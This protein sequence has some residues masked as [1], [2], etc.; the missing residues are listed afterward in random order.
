MATD[1]TIDRDTRSGE[2]V[3]SATSAHTAEDGDDT[4]TL[5]D[6]GHVA[7]LGGGADSLTAGDGGS[8]VLGDSGAAVAGYGFNH[9]DDE[10]CGHGAMATRSSRARATM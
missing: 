8:L 3:L 10:R 6:G 1:G 7:V 2:I 9:G 5:G 4:V